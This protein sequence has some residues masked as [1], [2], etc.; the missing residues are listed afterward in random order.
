MFTTCLIQHIRRGG[1]Y[2]DSSKG[3][4]IRPILAPGV[5]E[6]HIFS[7]QVVDGITTFKFKINVKNVLRSTRG[8]ED[9]CPHLEAKF[10]SQHQCKTKQHWLWTD[11]HTEFDF[12]R[13][14]VKNKCITTH[15]SDSIGIWILLWIDFTAFLF[16]NGTCEYELTNL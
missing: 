8:L 11:F 14:R 16:K 12:L 5:G 3:L 4:I 9:E 10:W 7:Q 15:L 13:E 6:N 1:T 2:L